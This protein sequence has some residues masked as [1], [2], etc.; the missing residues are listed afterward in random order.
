MQ[1]MEIIKRNTN[2]GDFYCTI[3]GAFSSCFLARKQK[4]KI[5]AKYAAATF[6]ALT[7]MSLATI[8]PN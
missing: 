6:E 7:R 1:K 5:V 2:I 3:W 8:T 4:I